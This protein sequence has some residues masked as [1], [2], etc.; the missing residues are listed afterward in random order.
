MFEQV[1]QYSSKWAAIVSIAGKV[2]VSTESLR[3]WVRQVDAGARA[4]S[5]SDYSTELRKLRQEVRNC[6]E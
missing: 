5:T 2:G 6:V 3:R 1:V 4:G